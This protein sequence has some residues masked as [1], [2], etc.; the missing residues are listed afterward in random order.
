MHTTLL[1]HHIK[2]MRNH[3]AY[4]DLVSKKRLLNLVI[5]IWA[6][7]FPI[8][9]IFLFQV[10]LFF[11]ISVLQAFFLLSLPKISLFLSLPKVSF[12][13]SLLWALF[14]LSLLWV[15]FLLSLLF[16]LLYNFTIF[17]IRPYKFLSVIFIVTFGSLV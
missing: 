16:F 6:W 3:V 5:W 9:T 13:L 2:D 17:H 10:V 15:L 14:L 8:Q 7:T 12:L 1:M 11:F 4:R